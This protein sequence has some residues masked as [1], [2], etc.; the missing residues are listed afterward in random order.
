LFKEVISLF[1]YF[2]TEKTVQICRWILLRSSYKPDV[3]CY[4]L[5]IDAFGQKLLYKE[6]ESTYLQLLETRCIPTEDTY[7]LLIKAFCL[8]GLLEK[9]EA[10]F[11]ETRSYGLPPSMFLNYLLHPHMFYL[12]DIQV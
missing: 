7:A 11:A 5:L 10:V 12:L 2:T 9:A 1:W 8:S 3:I 4:N 6:A